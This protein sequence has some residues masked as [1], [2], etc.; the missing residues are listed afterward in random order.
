MAPNQLLIKTGQVTEFNLA[1]NDLLIQN[2]FVHVLDEKEKEKKSRNILLQNLTR[3]IFECD[4]FAVSDMA[5]LSIKV[6]L[7]IATGYK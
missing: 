5:T 4:K 7:R 6:T 2:S 3:V 1:Q